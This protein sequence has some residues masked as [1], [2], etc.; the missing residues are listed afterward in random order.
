MDAV[1]TILFGGILLVLA[2]WAFFLKRKADKF[3][4]Y[5]EKSE[6]LFDMSENRLQKVKDIL[7]E[8]GCQPKLTTEEGGQRIE[9]A[10]QGETFLIAANDES[11]YICIWDYAW[12]VMELDDPRISLI[13]ECLNLMSPEWN[14][15]LYYYEDVENN[16][17]VVCTK[18]LL[19]LPTGKYN[20]KD[21]IERIFVSMIELKNDLRRKYEEVTKNIG[22]DNSFASDNSNSKLWN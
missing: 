5:V 7:C 19:H 20:P 18:M 13:K 9:V 4:H 2:V 15:V 1:F 17:F 10:F 6:D 3:D 16:C 8:M 22:E 12:V 11:A 21:P 14:M